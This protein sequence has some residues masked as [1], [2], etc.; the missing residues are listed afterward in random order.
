VQ[1]IERTAVVRFAGAEFLLEA[2][3]VRAVGE[4]LERLIAEG[5]T[6]RLV[7]NFRG[8]RY[9]AS[10]V[11]GELAALQKGSDRAGG[12]IRVCGLDPLLRDMLRVTRL[13][14]ALDVCGDEAEALGLLAP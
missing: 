6:T 1:V 11:L 8:V 5:G 10:E 9:L 7:L 14:R 4:R 12:Q 2:A 13:D 3:A